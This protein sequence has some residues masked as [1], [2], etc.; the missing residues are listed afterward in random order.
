MIMYHYFLL[1][2]SVENVGNSSYE[3]T[4][5]A[6]RDSIGTLTLEAVKSTNETIAFAIDGWEKL[7]NVET[8]ISGQIW[9]YGEDEESDSAKE[10]FSK[11]LVRTLFRNILEDKNATRDTTIIHCAMIIGGAGQTFTFK[12]LPRA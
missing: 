5:K 12:V 7:K 11:K 6:V 3:S 8:A 9:I 2:Y 10:A 4:A 1:T